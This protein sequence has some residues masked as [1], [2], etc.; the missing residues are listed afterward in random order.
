MGAE[1]KTAEELAA[2][3]RM[4]YEKLDPS[5][6]IAWVKAQKADVIVIGDGDHFSND[7]RW[8]VGHPDVVKAFADSGKKLL[9]PEGPMDANLAL[10]ETFQA[11]QG[12][13]KDLKENNPALSPT[14]IDAV[15]QE[16]ITAVVRST[17]Q[18]AYAQPSVF[19]EFNPEKKFD[20]LM[21][22]AN[23]LFRA[24]A[25]GVLVQNADATLTMAA[26]P[27]D[28][29]DAATDPAAEALTKAMQRASSGQCYGVQKH[30]MQKAGVLPKGPV[31]SSQLASGNRGAEAFESANVA[32]YEATRQGHPAVMFPGAWHAFAKSGLVESLRAKGVNAASVMV[33]PQFSSRVA[34]T[35]AAPEITERPDAMFFVNE[36]Q[37]LTGQEAKAA[38]EARMP[39]AKSFPILLRG[40]AEQCFSKQWLDT[41]PKEE[42]TMLEAALRNGGVSYADLL[43]LKYQKLPLRVADHGPETPGIPVLVIPQ[44]RADAG[45]RTQQ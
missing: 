29:K 3:A 19:H 36:G 30:W 45:N 8:L 21:A 44:L 16:K 2:T 9:L 10:R 11:I 43:E 14:Q 32:A 33:F 22:D 1:P 39:T 27:T 5:A 26:A 24:M 20:R 17:A 15:V 4:G 38:F 42:R 12:F 13:A 41:L 25:A 23:L 28:E 31:D 7:I 40:E 6:L 35:A 34:D 18:Q 37:L